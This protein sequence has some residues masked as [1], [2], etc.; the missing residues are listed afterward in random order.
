MSCI[1]L[2]IAKLVHK[3]FINYIFLIFGKIISNQGF[4]GLDILYLK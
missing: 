4:K 2:V 3:L 1:F